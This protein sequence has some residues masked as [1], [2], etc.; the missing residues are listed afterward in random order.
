MNIMLLS[1]NNV[2]IHKLAVISFLLC[3]YMAYL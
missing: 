3:V 1:V 2:L